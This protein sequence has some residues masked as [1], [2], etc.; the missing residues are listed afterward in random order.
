MSALLQCRVSPPQG[1]LTQRLCCK[2]PGALITGPPSAPT[3]RRKQTLA[4]VVSEGTTPG[5][6]S[7]E[8]VTLSMFLERKQQ[9][10]PGSCYW[11]PSHR[12]A[13]CSARP[14]SPPHPSLYLESASSAA[15]KGSE[16]QLGPTEALHSPSPTEVSF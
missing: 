4:I 3:P 9:N 5:P 6:V 13:Q 8:S 15:S 14:C 16:Q 10:A 12:Y 11:F 1:Q 2:D 7:T